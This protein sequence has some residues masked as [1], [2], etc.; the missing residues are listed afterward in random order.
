MNRA[1]AVSYYD[2]SPLKATLERLVDFDRVNAAGMSA[3]RIV[4]APDRSCTA[5]ATRSVGVSSGAFRRAI[6]PRT[7]MIPSFLS[8]YRPN[9]NLTPSNTGAQ[10][11]SR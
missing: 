4:N 7:F 5:L 2:V 9:A 6:A 1:D 8:L 3:S 10:F 11:D